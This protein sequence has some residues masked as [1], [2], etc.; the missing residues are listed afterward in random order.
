[1]QSSYAFD[2]RLNCTLE[3]AV[4]RLMGWVNGAMRTESTGGPG[5]EPRQLAFVDDT[6]WP[7]LQYQLEHLQSAAREEL[8]EAIKSREWPAVIG[9]KRLAVTACDEMSDRAL[10]CYSDIRAEV[11]KG[12]NSSIRLDAAKTRKTGAPHY[13][14][15]TIASWAESR[16]S[17]DVAVTGAPRLEP[18]LARSVETAEPFALEMQFQT[19]SMAAEPVNGNEADWEEGSLKKGYLVTLALLLEDVAAL[20][21]PHAHDDHEPN[22]NFIALKLAERWKKQSRGRPGRGQG[23]ERIRQRLRDARSAKSEMLQPKG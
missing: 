19:D 2:S 22:L 9:A 13:V 3:V 20:S 6:E 16:H 14:W 12:K 1:M 23:A 7:S 15:Q 4:A 8:D 10:S 11:K 18:D 21:G 17:G 5:V